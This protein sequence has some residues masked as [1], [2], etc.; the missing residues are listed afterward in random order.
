[1][2]IFFVGQEDQ[3]GRRP[4]TPLLG[5]GEAE[6]PLVH[7]QVLLHHYER[8]ATIHHRFRAHH[9]THFRRSLGE[10]AHFG[11]TSQRFI[12]NL[13]LMIMHLL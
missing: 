13:H 7:V 2:I 6:V 12:F 10:K 8:H 11:S 4:G 3:R 1:M 5:R 9:P